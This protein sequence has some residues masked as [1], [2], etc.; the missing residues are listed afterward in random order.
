M[1][2]VPSTAVLRSDRAL[3]A[4]KRNNY[5]DIGLPGLILSDN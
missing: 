3:V 4:V 2:H 1:S 5:S